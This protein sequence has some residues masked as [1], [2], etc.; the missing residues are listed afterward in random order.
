MLGTDLM[1]GEVKSCLSQKM[2]LLYQLF[3]K[4]KLWKKRKRNM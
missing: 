4:Q 3:E 1:D 2:Y